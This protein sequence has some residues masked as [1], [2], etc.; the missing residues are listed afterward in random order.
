LLHKL[1]Q[2]SLP[3]I[4]DRLGYLTRTN[5]E[6]LL[7]V[8]MSKPQRDYTQGVAIT[9]SWHPD[10]NTHIEP[11]RYGK[12][13]NAMGLLNTIMTDGGTR[14]H[15]WWQF[16][17]GLLRHP[18]R[19]RFLIPRRWSE[20]VII[21]LVMQTLNNS[22]TVKR[23]RTRFRRSRLTS[24]QGEGEP[25]PTW[26]PVANQAASQLAENVGGVAGGTWGDLFNIPMTAHFIGGCV[27]G[28]SAERGVVD[29]YHRLYGHAGLHVVDG[30]TLSANLGVNP[31]LS[32]TAQAERAMSLWPNKGEAD[33]R[34]ALG[35][36]YKRINSVAPRSPAVPDNAPGT[37]RYPAVRP[38]MP[39]SRTA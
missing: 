2:S 29:P 37:L 19:V 22:I 16:L 14:R 15:R 31:S 1:K 34:P 27:I 18:L 26:I 9:S 35:S 21:L 30:S 38:G 7:G 36:G 20:R 24:E 6:A 17:L 12:G 4:S 25:N 13:S 32:I 28:D 33:L 11:V 23:V 8:R 5:S 10:E 39:G 3:N